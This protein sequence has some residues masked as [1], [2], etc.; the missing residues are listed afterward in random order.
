MKENNILAISS[1]VVAL[2]AAFGQCISVW[3]TWRPSVVLYIIS[4][5]KG[6]YIKMKNFGGSIAKISRFST[7]VDLQKYK[8]NTNKPF[9]YVG[10]SNFILAP[11][12]SLLAVIDN[13]YLNKDCWI[14]VAYKSSVGITRK[15]RLPLQSPNIYALVSEN[16]FD[17]KDY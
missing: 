17:Y 9:P 15:Y 2:L 11:G 13:K 3:I 14:E 12:T 6:T 10:L 1:F 7:N 5:K 8:S 4:T 16:D